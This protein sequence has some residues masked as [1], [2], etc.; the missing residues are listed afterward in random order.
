MPGLS[1]D[2]PGVVNESELDL[3]QSMDEDLSRLNQ[4]NFTD[5]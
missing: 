1:A 4:S 5:S 3:D 2:D